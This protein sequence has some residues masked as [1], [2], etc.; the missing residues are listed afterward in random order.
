MMPI[1]TIS[2]QYEKRLK[3]SWFHV[4]A[5]GMG[6]SSS[7]E[8]LRPQEWPVLVQ[9]FVPWPQS[10]DNHGK[11]MGKPWENGGLLVV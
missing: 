9:I 3:L 5:I 4:S 10:S 8:V 6:N 2:L 11:T 1:F 7:W